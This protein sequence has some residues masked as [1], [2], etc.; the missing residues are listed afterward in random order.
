VP[1]SGPQG[2]LDPP[3]W[4]WSSVAA[5]EPSASGEPPP[6][7]CRAGSWV[8]AAANARLASAGAAERCQEKSV[9]RLPA[10]WTGLSLQRAKLVTE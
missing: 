6:I 7:A 2:E 3:A 5:S 10:G 9:G 8:R 4:R 1:L